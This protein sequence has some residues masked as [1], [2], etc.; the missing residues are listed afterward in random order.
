MQSEKP[1]TQ[2][3]DSHSIHEVQTLSD[4][5]A[6]GASATRTGHHALALNEPAHIM[7]PALSL[8]PTAAADLAF[9]HQ[10]HP[11]QAG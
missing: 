6:N 4:R 5:I 11:L 9:E 2:T 1:V 7:D 8:P 10:I 3:D